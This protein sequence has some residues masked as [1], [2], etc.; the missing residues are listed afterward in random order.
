[1]PNVDFGT[2]RHP[3]RLAGTLEKSDQQIERAIELHV[4]AAARVR[5]AG[6]DGLEITA[7]KGYLIHQFLN[8][9]INRR[10]DDWGGTPEK[11]FQFL[12]RILTGVRARVGPDFPVGIRLSGEDLNGAPWPLAL[13]RWPSPFLSR[14]RWIG[15]DICQMKAYAKRLEE[16]RADF[17]H[18]TA[19][20]G[21][22]NPRDVPGRFPFEEVRMFFDSVRHLSTKAAIRAAITH[23]GPLWAWEWLLNRGWK[24]NDAP[25]LGLA[26]ELKSAVTIPVIAN[27]VFR[28]VKTIHD[29][30]QDGACSMVSMA[31]AL[32]ATPTFVLDYLRSGLEVPTGTR[33]THCNRCVGRTA[34]SPLGCYEPSRF[35]NNMQKMERQILAFNAPDEPY[36]AIAAMPSTPRRKQADSVRTLE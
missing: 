31:R 15:N 35:D 26:K 24:D 7:S 27:G 33:C 20:F 19:G 11:R 30:L 25:N 5:E 22:P 1:M 21:F 29:A 4:A 28:G 32:I 17:L 8:P 16:L 10:D 36:D 18:V 2:R 14:E 23:V 34:T 6:A 13:A 3:H 9:A 12:S